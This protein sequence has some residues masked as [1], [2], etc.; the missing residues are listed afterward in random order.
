VK[1]LKLAGAALITLFCIQLAVLV[2]PTAA[3]AQDAEGQK[4][5]NTGTNPLNFTYDMRFITGMDWLRDDGGSMVKNTFQFSAPLGRDLSNLTGAGRWD[6]LGKKFALRFRGYWNTLSV[7]NPSQRTVSGI[8]D[9]DGRLLW[10]AHVN[11]KWGVAPGLEAFFNTASDDALGTGKTS[12]AP[13]LFFTLFNVLGRGSI[14]APGYQYVFSVGGDPDRSDVQQSRIDLYFV[15]MLAKGKNW[16]VVNPQVILDHENSTEFMQTDLEF[17][18][19]IVPQSGISGYL[20]PGF[21]VGDG[22]PFN[23][24]FEFAFKFVWR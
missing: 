9:F 13:T 5:D 23:W 10:L 1:T 22:R 11:N 8:G 2:A 20:R 16:L 7:D 17:G 12:L 18:Y 6:D 19:M 15:W 14:F 21:A 4:E 3:Q 24:N